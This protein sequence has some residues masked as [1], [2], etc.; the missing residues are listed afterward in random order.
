MPLSCAGGPGGN[1]GLEIL[2]QLLSDGGGGGVNS[3]ICAS[4]CLARCRCFSPRRLAQPAL[5]VLFCGFFFHT[6][7]SIVFSWDSLTSFL[8]IFYLWHNSTCRPRQ[9]DVFQDITAHLATGCGWSSCFCV[10]GQS[11]RS[12]P[13]HF[14]V[15]GAT[16][17]FVRIPH[18]QT[19]ELTR[20]SFP[21]S[22]GAY[23]CFRTHQWVGGICQ[24]CVHCGC[25]SGRWW[26]W[27]GQC[28]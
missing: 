5:S 7:I 15:P 11:P 2:L 23:G 22:C 1:S 3:P 14:M 26:A 20:H 19:V 8:P 4:R 13:K 10:F 16:K 6:A 27:C 24:V 21:C 18:A 28:I 25:H 9:Y 12:D 17:V